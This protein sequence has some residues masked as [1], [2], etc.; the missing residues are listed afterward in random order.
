MTVEIQNQKLLNRVL[1]EIRS[2]RDEFEEKRHVPRDMVAQ[3]KQ[4]GVYRAHTPRCFGGDACSPTEFLRLI[5]DISEADGSAGWVA[6]FGSAAVYLASLPRD[7][8]ARIYANGPDVS[9]AGGLFPVQPAEKVASGWRVNGLWK[10]AS[11]CKGA[12]IL[13]VGIGTGDGG[14]PLTAVLMPEDVEIV[15][16]WEVFGMRGTGSHDL[17]VKDAFV[18]DDWTFVRGGVPSIEEPIFQYP[19]IAY[20]SQVL[21]V[22][23]LG[24]ARAALNEVSQMAGGHPS[25]TGAPKMADRAYIRIAVAKAEASLRSARAFFY[26]ATD[27]AWDSILRGDGVSADQTSML[28]LAAVK[29]ARAGASAVQSAYLLAGTAAIYDGHPLQRYLRDAMVVTQ[30]A[31]L[32]EGIY[33]GAGSVFLGVPPMPGYI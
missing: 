2:R 18:S 17:R 30:H 32:S 25:I 6:S 33:D 21:A 19:S 8:L 26:E 13:G 22:V 1:N 12:D 20:A 5:E 10:F 27:S 31:F 28:R 9:F 4:L 15:E 29:A 16:N 3:L 11:G 24:V 14:K 7:T 23:N